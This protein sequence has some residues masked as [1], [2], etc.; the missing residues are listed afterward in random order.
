MAVTYW[1]LFRLGRFRAHY[2]TRSWC[3]RIEKCPWVFQGGKW[4]LRIC[5]LEVEWR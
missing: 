2:F 5:G 1:R 4:Y 3:K